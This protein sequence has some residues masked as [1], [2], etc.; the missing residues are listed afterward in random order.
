MHNFQYHANKFQKTFYSRPLHHA[1]NPHGQA[2]NDSTLHVLK[3]D[4]AKK[5]GMICHFYP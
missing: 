4:E 3:V 2:Q 5:E 1:K